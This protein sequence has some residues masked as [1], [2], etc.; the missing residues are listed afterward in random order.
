[1]SK[2]GRG[3]YYNEAGYSI[4]DYGKEF[5]GETKY[6]KLLEIKKKWDPKNL[7]NCRQ[8]VGWEEPEMEG[9]A[10]LLRASG[11]LVYVPA[12]VALLHASLK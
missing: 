10:Y 9:G 5:W 2:H 11:L 8:C 12:F 1:M 6:K 7:F 4:P 3:V